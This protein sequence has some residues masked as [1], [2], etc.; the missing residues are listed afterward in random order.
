[1]PTGKSFSAFQKLLHAGAETGESD[2]WSGIHFLE[3][4]PDHFFINLPTVVAAPL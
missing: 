4:P 3:T 2:P 1:M